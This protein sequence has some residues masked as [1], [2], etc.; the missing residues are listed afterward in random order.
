MKKKI[1]VLLTVTAIM[2]GTSVPTYA[3]TSSYKPLSEYGYNGVPDINI[4]LDDMLKKY[5]LNIP[6]IT[7]ADEYSILRKK[8]I[9]IKWNKID[10]A[11]GYDIKITKE[12]D[13]VETYQS[14]Y[15]FILIV[16]VTNPLS[17]KVRAYDNDGHFSYWSIKEIK[18]I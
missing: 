12:D 1:L 15:N 11:T 10:G 8:I 3:V 2:L 14:K 5:T 6:Q 18:C 7:K 16:N 4:N 9:Y 17:V 13:N